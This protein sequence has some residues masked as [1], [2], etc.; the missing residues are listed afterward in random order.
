[1]IIRNIFIL[2]CCL[3]RVSSANLQIPF[4]SNKEAVS[5]KSIYHHTNINGLSPN[6]FRRMEIPAINQAS[7]L[8]YTLKHVVG[9]TYRPS[10]QYKQELFDLRK[11]GKLLRWSQGELLYP[12]QSLIPD[13]TDH[14]SILS[15][16]EMS[17]NAY[18]E[19]GKDGQ[20]YDLGGQ[21]RIVSNIYFYF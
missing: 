4:T 13:V 19:L 8:P 16:A 7:N 11:A 9:T 21:W 15:L 2:Y 3:I 14:A 12:E 6:Q 5:L 17:F 1:M 10:E 18:T 20:W